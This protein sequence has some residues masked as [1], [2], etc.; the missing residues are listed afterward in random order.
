MKVEE[1][2]TLMKNNSV[3]FT[4]KCCDCSCNV[5]LKARIENENTIVEGGAIYKPPSSWN[6]QDDYIFKCDQCYS[7]DSKFYPNTEVF[8]RIV[9]YMRPTSQW[10]NGKKAEFF[11][12][13]S[14]NV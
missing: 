1:L 9:G 3:E 10:N 7:K 6:Y 11:I 5:I 4:G 13:S 8:S 14:F 12:R 2:Y